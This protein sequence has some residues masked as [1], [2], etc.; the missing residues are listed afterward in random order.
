MIIK[1]DDDQSNVIQNDCPKSFSF[2]GIIS[3]MT[4][5]GKVKM[6][7]DAMNIVKLNEIIGI[8][9][10]ASTSY[11]HVFSIIYTPKTHKPS[12]VPMVETA[13]KNFKVQ[14]YSH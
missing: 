11:C 13:N 3:E 5:N 12:P 6:A 14:K 2:S 4:K 10:N 7:H 1:N 8:E 9:L